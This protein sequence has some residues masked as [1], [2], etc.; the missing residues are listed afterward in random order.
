MAVMRE[1]ILIVMPS[2]LER[3]GLEDFLKLQGHQIFLSEDLNRSLSIIENRPISFV[4][5]YD[6][7]DDFWTSS[8]NGSFYHEAVEEK[9][10]PLV[11]IRSKSFSPEQLSGLG[12]IH[13][14][15]FPLNKEEV[16]GL[17]LALKPQIE[18]VPTVAAPSDDS[19]NYSSVPIDAFI[20]L[21]V[22]SYDLYHKMNKGPNDEKF[23]CIARA[24]LDFS[25]ELFHKLKKHGVD[26][27]YLKK[28][29]FKKYVN[30]HIQKLDNLHKN[31]DFSKKEKTMLLE[32]TS[33]IIL[34]QV[35]VE[36]IDP[37]NFHY[38]K[39]IVESSMELIMDNSTLFELINVLNTTNEGQYRHAL[40]MSIYS[41]LMAKELE[42]FSPQNKAKLGISAILADIG[43]K[44]INPEILKKPRILMD[45]KEVAE[46]QQH[47]QF[48]ADMLR[49]IKGIPNDILQIILQHHENHDG[50]GF[51]S[52]S[53]RD[54]IHPMARVLRIADE[55][56]SLVIKSPN[57]GDN[58]ISPLKA[59]SDMN[60]PLYRGKFDQRSLDALNLI[61]NPQKHKKIA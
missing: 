14:F 13:S 10:I 5:V 19:F 54:D 2:C 37:D 15:S 57:N 45:F 30:I 16:S 48:S 55:F 24:N 58:V 4:M 61:F 17:I 27:I 25:K 59:L 50:T 34:E 6:K 42:W 46:Y 38:S 28:E 43:L 8:F 44:Q 56:C 33:Q 36:G 26:K 40:S 22:S 23:L 1:N 29:D 12:L 31:S 60:G 9:K 53:R 20:Y 35:Y 47:A 52:K 41:V 21:G 18:S 49:S 7:F 11:V 3:S 32:K 39:Q 51:P